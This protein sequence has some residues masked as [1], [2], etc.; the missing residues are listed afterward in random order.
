MF[1]NSYISG[2]ITNNF[3][4]YISAFEITQGHYR[5]LHLIFDVLNYS[6]CSIVRHPPSQLI[7][8]QIMN[9]LIIESNYI[10]KYSASQINNLVKSVELRND[11]LSVSDY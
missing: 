2:F 10:G 3:V 7:S 8:C 5:E 1:D 6:K 11:C 4:S 9:C